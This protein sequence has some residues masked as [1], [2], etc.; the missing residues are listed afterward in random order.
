MNPNVEQNEVEKADSF[1]A[2]FKKANPLSTDN[3]KKFRQV[4]IDLYS[5]E[6]QCPP[7]VREERKA[8]FQEMFESLKSKDK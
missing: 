3:E 6:E 4:L 1:L 7:S 8:R 2:E 5:E